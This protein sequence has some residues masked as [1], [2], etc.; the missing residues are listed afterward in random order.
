M[1]YRL[2]FCWWIIYYT[3]V[4]LC[5]SQSM[6]SYKRVNVPEICGIQSQKLRRTPFFP[7]L[8]MTGWN[9]LHKWLILQRDIR[10]NNQSSRVSLSFV[11]SKRIVKSYQITK[12]FTVVT[13]DIWPLRRCC[14]VPR[15][16]TNEKIRVFYNVFPYLWFNSG[17][18]RKRKHE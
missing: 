9:N 5:I 4:E 11:N 1:S 16:R 13:D 18:E 15:R 7:S 3:W 12:W 8:S 17:N 14:I 2:L 10:M 6:S